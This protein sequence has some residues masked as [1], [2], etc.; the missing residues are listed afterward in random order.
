MSQDSTRCTLPDYEAPRLEPA[1]AFRGPRSRV[2][3]IPIDAWNL[4]CSDCSSNG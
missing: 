1:A 4:V 2:T 3:G